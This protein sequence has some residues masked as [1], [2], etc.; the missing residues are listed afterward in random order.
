MWPILTTVYLGFL[1]LRITVSYIK[2]AKSSP[3]ETEHIL[4]KDEDKK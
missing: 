1:G 4:I 3:E 2:P